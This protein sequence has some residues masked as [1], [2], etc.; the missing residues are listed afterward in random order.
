[1]RHLSTP[2]SKASIS[3]LH[4]SN[5]TLQ[6]HT[7][8]FPTCNFF[9]V[10][11]ELFN[12]TG[13]VVAPSFSK[14]VPCTFQQNIIESVSQLLTEFDHNITS[15][16]V[17][18][19][20]NQASYA[21]C[22]SLNKV[23]TA[24]REYG[25]WFSSHVGPA[26][27]AVAYVATED[28]S[29]TAGGP[30]SSI[31]ALDQYTLPNLRELPLVILP[32][33][34]AENVSSIVEYLPAIAVLQQVYR[35]FIWTLF[36]ISMFLIV[37]TIIILGLLARSKQLKLELRTFVVVI[38]L[39]SSILF[40]SQLL[41][42][43]ITFAARTL[44]EISY[45]L[46]FVAIYMLLLSCCLVLQ[47]FSYSFQLAINTFLITSYQM[48]FKTVILYLNIF[49]Y[50]TSAFNFLYYTF[51]FYLKQKNHEI[52][53]S[54]CYVLARMSYISLFCFISYIM[55]DLSDIMY[56]VP[57]LSNTIPISIMRLVFFYL[58]NTIRSFV[59]LFIL[60]MRVND[61]SIAARVVNCVDIYNIWVLLR[62]NQY[63][64]ESHNSNAK[65]WNLSTNKMMNSFPTD[66]S[67]EVSFD[68]YDIGNNFS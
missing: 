37:R 53:L 51:F 48:I 50:T 6:K 38:A 49:L 35:V 25:N 1:M 12:I 7:P 43:Y 46:S 34:R 26:I 47:I 67:S 10:P 56:L 45:I 14:T 41:L 61:E 23:Y 27:T 59:L 29:H 19:H 42:N 44:S 13:I 18:A 28:A 17:L 57:S 8:T 58:A 60:G 65:K 22:T 24:A 20:Q 31:Y 11:A 36:A 55:L 63:Q 32:E 40:T 4:H 5:N 9:G 30:F 52:S 68:D 2:L 16:I 54:T 66:N 39:A 15:V 3:L 33:S 21:H 64:V 62:N